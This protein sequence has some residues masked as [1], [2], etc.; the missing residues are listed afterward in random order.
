MVQFRQD[1]IAA[2]RVPAGIDGQLQRLDLE[3]GQWVNSGQELARVAQPGRFKAVLRVPETQAPDVAVGQLVDI[4]LR[5][6]IVKGTVM[7]IDAVSTNATVEVE[8]SL[9]G[10]MPPGARADLSVD[11]TILVERLPDVM[12]VQRPAYG[13][14]NQTVGLFKLDA[15]GGTATRVNVQ[16]G[17]A[18]VNQIEVKA[19]LEPGDRVIISDMSNFDLAAKVRI[20]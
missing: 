6:A 10:D 16:L 20:N 15:D 18:S 12:F 9:D 5:P 1:R 11:G 7:R 13:Q 4:D 17:K 8:V 3:L 19:G 2:L 14:A